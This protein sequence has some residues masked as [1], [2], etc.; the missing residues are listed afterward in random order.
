MQCFNCRKDIPDDAKACK[1]CEAPVEDPP[2]DEEMELVA[3]LLDS[4]D[5]EL[6]SAIRAAATNS[7][8]AEEFAN[9]MMIGDCPTCASDDVGDCG[10]DPEIEHP[11]LGR[12]YECGQLWCLDCGEL[13][14]PGAVECPHEAIC[15]ACELEEACETFPGDCATILQWQA[16]REG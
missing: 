6:Q 1:F 13:L 7:A 16:G 8:T 3:G 14:D 11:C 2:T 5:P 10:E 12:C 4:M 9:R 15:A